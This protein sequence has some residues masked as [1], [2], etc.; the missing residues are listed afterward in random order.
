MAPL[1]PLPVE[2]G[3]P[4]GLGEGRT[5]AV[6]PRHGR[7]TEPADEPHEAGDALGERGQVT[8]VAHQPAERQVAVGA[9]ELR[10]VGRDARVGDDRAGAV[11]AVERPLDRAVEHAAVPRRQL[12]LGRQ[13]G[14]ERD[15]GGAW[16]GAVPGPVDRHGLVVAAPHR[17]GR[18]VAE[19]VDGGPRLA[20]R[21]LPGAA[22]VAPLE[23][24][25][26]PQQHPGL[27]GRV[28]QLGP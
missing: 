4:V 24:E 23:R 19:E 3:P 27:V 8:F 21:L 13:A 1:E 20:R 15:A 2:L 10:Q 16:P 12:L 22:R 17:D 18:M 6:P 7:R 9:V 28:V 14:G 11:G 25:V 5:L 26:L